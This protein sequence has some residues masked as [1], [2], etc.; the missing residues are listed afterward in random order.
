MPQKY[1]IYVLVFNNNRVKAI[2]INNEF[3]RST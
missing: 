2:V 3:F 1:N